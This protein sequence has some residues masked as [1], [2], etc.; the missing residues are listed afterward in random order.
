MC[1]SEND[2]IIP[3]LTNNPINVLEQVKQIAYKRGEI[4]KGTE[5]YQESLK[6]VVLYIQKGRLKTVMFNYYGAE[7]L[8]FYLEENTFCLP[9]VT[10]A[11]SETISTRIIAVE[12]CELIYIKEYDYLTYIFTNR[13]MFDEFLQGIR[14]RFAITAANVMDSMFGARGRLYK[15][16]Y[17][18]AFNNR[19]ADKNGNILIENFPSRGDIASIT[20]VHRNNITTYLRDLEKMG[21]I[22]KVKHDILVKDIDKLKCLIDQEFN[23][24]E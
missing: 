23:K 9:M 7:K 20:G 11:F 1:T 19:T 5:I 16:I 3:Y 6:D 18:M 17:H 12:D 4:K 14:K 8:L 15:F 24:Y 10:G 22:E 21:V 2:Y 13:K